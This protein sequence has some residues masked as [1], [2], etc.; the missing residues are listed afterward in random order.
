MLEPELTRH[1]LG[2]RYPMLP[3]VA[4]RYLPIHPDLVQRR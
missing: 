4:F 3:R 1:A 2:Q